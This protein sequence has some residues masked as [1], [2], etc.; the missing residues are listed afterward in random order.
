MSMQM[1][2]VT[3]NGE[4]VAGSLAVP[5]EAAMLAAMQLNK[6]YRRRDLFDVEEDPT[7]TPYEE[8]QAQQFAN[9]AAAALR[10]PIVAPTC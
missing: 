6:E 7:A 5:Y 10:L 8:G 9:M 2:C 3:R 1:Y 4:R